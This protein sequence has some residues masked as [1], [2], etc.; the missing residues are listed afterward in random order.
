[1]K[2]ILRCLYVRMDA[3]FIYIR[4]HRGKQQLHTQLCSFYVN[5]KDKA[6]P[7]KKRVFLGTRAGSQRKAKLDLLLETSSS[8]SEPGPE[9]SAAAQPENVY[10]L[11][12]DIFEFSGKKKHKT[13]S[14]IVRLQVRY[15]V[16]DCIKMHVAKKG[17]LNGSAYGFHVSARDGERQQ[18]KPPKKVLRTHTPRVQKL[19]CIQ[20]M[21]G[22]SKSQKRSKLFP[23]T[24][25]SCWVFVSLR[26]R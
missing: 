3:A 9:F 18:T 24:D 26:S 4:K 8:R 21:V 5:M 2:I 20:R 19:F 16:S 13:L 23:L 17:N 6:V 1:M 15:K 12:F 11:I 14:N 10:F 25:I 22:A 7:A